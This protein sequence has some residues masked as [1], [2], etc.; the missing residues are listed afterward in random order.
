MKNIL[1]LSALVA[2]FFISVGLANAI[3]I[4][5]TSTSLISNT[6]NF[7]NISFYN[8]QN[9]TVSVNL[10]INS[11]D[12]RYGG[13]FYSISARPSSFIL[14]PGQTQ[15][16]LFSFSTRDVFYSTPTPINISY[17]VNGTP[18]SFVLNAPILPHSTKQIYFYN[19]SLPAETYPYE[20][21]PVNLTIINSL[22]STGV[23]VPVNFSLFYGNGTL[24]LSEYKSFTLTNLGI[25]SYS[26]YIRPSAISPPGTYTLSSSLSYNGFVSTFSRSITFLRYYKVVVSRSSSIG[27]FGGTYYLTISNEGNAPSNITNYTL[28]PGSLN[29]LLMVSKGASIGSVAAGANG[30]YSSL[31]VISPGQTV[32]LHYSVSYVII[33]I[34][35]LI[36]IIAVILF[37]YFNRKVEVVKEVV[38]HEASSGFIDVKISI[39]VKNV[40][41]KAI[42]N[43]DLF[44]ITPKSA[45]KVSMIGPREG[46]IQKTVDGLKLLWKENR[47]N[48]GDEFIVMYELK[49]KIGIVGSVQLNPAV[50]KFKLNG[51]IYKRKS[52][53]II[54]NI[55]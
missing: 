16:V 52:N 54:L 55:R 3:E 19:V 5:P 2:V 48:P 21:I 25:N 22:D 31:G 32:S 37:F 9:Y 53:S 34:I 15:R 10:N 14:S 20:S 51:N 4:S 36:I 46:V 49:S 33:Y 44:D 6:T 45:L 24:A 12:A 27:I 23:V 8:Q 11:V 26:V 30:L 28:S 39:K 38:K 7:L 17:T 13:F 47:L 35:I 1:I 40:S 18:Q 50:C 29:S 41:N 42:E 43:I